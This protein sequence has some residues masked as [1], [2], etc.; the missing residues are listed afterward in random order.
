MKPTRAHRLIRI[1]RTLQTG[2][3]CGAD[4]LADD[5]GVSRRTVFRDISVLKDAGIPCSYDAQTESYAIDHAYYLTPL[6]LSL[7]EALALMLLTR[8]FVDDRI[9]PLSSAA[10][11]AGMK[12][13]MALP[14]DIRTHCGALLDGVEVGGLQVSDV[15]AVTDALLRTEEAVAARRKI[16]MRY[17][18][19]YEKGEIRTVIHPYRVVFRSRGWYV[20]GHSEAHCEVRTFKLERI[21]D[22]TVRD[23]V[24]S[25]PR[26]FDLDDYFG[27]AWNMVRGDRRHHVEVHF[28]AK[29]AGN[30]EEVAW[31]KTQR[32]RR[33][34]D[35]T[36][37]FEV[38]VDGIEEISWWIL[39]YGDQALVTEPDELRSLIASH[40]KTL[41]HYYNGGAQA[42]VERP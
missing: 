10:L 14:S 26:D 31:H 42:P 2:R 36:L 7:E 18:S 4:A 23:D 13:E 41:T 12:I 37:V 39:G 21:V 28:T 35:G 17:E 30:V 8:K 16:D 32:T 5:L 11:S 15:D 40:A 34:S 27:N 3:R 1:V 22:M 25:L 20:I 6:D 9:V 19:Y 33:R 29:V 24:F 38:D